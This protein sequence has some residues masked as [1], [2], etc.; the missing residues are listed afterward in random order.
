MK[1]EKG[2]GTG[3]R[4]LARIAFVLL[5]VLAVLQCFAFA[6]FGEWGIYT[7]S[8]SRVEE[9]QTD[10][11]ARSCARN[12]LRQ[13]LYHN[14]ETAHAEA[15]GI[16]PETNINFQI[17]YDGKLIDEIVNVEDMI[18]AYLPD[19]A[20]GDFRLV[21]NLDIGKTSDGRDDRSVWN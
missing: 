18:E 1:K 20:K 16:Y 15:A 2:M 17:Y 8:K 4:I 14:V 6:V 11:L 5:S 12:V 3:G 13:Y 19:S 10:A 9:Q 7:E 21:Y